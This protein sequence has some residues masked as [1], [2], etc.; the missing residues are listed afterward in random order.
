MKMYCLTYQMPC[1]IGV[2]HNIHISVLTQIGHLA[3]FGFCFNSCHPDSIHL[4]P[5]V[6]QL[7]LS[8]NHP[9]GSQVIIRLLTVWL[10]T[11]CLYRYC[12]ENRWSD[13]FVAIIFLPIW[14]LK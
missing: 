4:I 12:I 14:N 9:D 5:V 8:A 7:L 1:S 10:S 6:W 11:V 2:C 13:D 3:L